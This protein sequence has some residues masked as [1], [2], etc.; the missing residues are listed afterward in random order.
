MSKKKN[1]E[2]STV[3]KKAVKKEVKKEEIKEVVKDNKK[4]VKDNKKEVKDS[5][6]KVDSDKLKEKAIKGFEKIDENRKIIYGFAAGLLLGLLI[7]ALQPKKIAELKDGTQ[8]VA[9]L[10]DVAI[11]ADE[12]YADMKKQYSV[13]LLIDLIDNDILT[14][15]Y[16]E[17]DE[18]K[19]DVEK[20]ATYWFNT[21]NSYYGYDEET[22]LAKNG[23]SNRQAFI[24]YLTLDYRRNLYYEEYLKKQF[25]DK[26]IEKYYE[27]SV[28]GDIN[29]K[30]MLVS[31]DESKGLSDAD[32]KKLAEEII[33]KL[34]NG[35]SWDDVKAEYKDKITAEDLGYQSFD[36]SLDEA[37]I[38]EMK[39]LENGTYSKTPIKSSYGYHVVY[40]IDQKE[41]PKL[42]DVKDAIIE[43]LG[44][45][46]E[47]KDKDIRYK[48]LI[49]MREESKL[50]FTDE[51]L[52]A[53][54][55][56]YVSSYK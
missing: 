46:L 3:E 7:L 35:A 24:E 18:M 11:T 44:K 54:Y 2:K 42:D 56:K 40:R 55:N 27:S 38:S 33:S 26:D 22:F 17:T 12:L 21:Y 1:T 41:K 15:K 19:A 13:S 4:E 31:V 51:D 23:F 9:Y 8:P 25:T 53:K 45:E 47:K 50:K 37:Y 36:A 29:T 16:P 5:K 32:A 20:T 48:A 49:T 52:E 10:G 39:N 43:Q 6:K 14:K 34:N 30:H 28:Y